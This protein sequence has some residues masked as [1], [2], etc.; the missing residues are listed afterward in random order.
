[1]GK[2]ETAIQK[3]HQREYMVAYYQKVGDDNTKLTNRIQWEYQTH[4]SVQKNNVGRITQR[5]EASR[6]ANLETRRSKLRSILQSDA[7]E[8]KKELS[9]LS[10]TPQERRA[11]LN[12]KAA[13]L[14]EEKE[15]KRAEYVEEQL[16]RQFRMTTDELRSAGDKKMMKLCETDRRQ[17]IELKALNKSAE[18][19]EKA[20]WKEI[21]EMNREK[22]IERERQEIEAK[23]RMDALTYDEIGTQLELIKAQREKQKQIQAEE[24]EELSRI[25]KEEEQKEKQNLKQHAERAAAQRVEILKYNSQVQAKKNKEALRK[26]NEGPEVSSIPALMRETDENLSERKQKLV[27]DMR[28]FLAYRQA[29]QRQAQERE[30]ELDAWR[31]AESE[32]VARRQDLAWQ[33]E[34]LAREKLMKEVIETRQM[35]ILEKG[36]FPFFKL[37]TF[38]RN[39]T[40]FW[41]LFIA[42]MHRQE[43]KLQNLEGS[44]CI[45]HEPDDVKS[46]AAARRAIFAESLKRQIEERQFQ[47][48][49][50]QAARQQEAFEAKIA[51]QDYQRRLRA[52]LDADQANFQ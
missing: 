15:R 16:R 6:E 19:L 2:N 17:Q 50:E 44:I 13:Q 14:R 36:N 12:E 31:G 20:R 30:K 39:Q 51:E 42:E 26:V 49:L 5:L 18:E 1:M 7:L 11:K 41:F 43:K 47:A 45:L 48:Q 52:E 28:R 46:T 4:Q 27:G 33:N 37:I 22:L 8:L 25:M 34:Q 3:E 21:G 32:R 10:E 9:A 23:K 40:N 24:A 38:C 29:Q 35:Q